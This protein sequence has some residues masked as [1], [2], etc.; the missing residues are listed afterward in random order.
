MQVEPFSFYSRDIT[1][2]CLG[3]VQSLVNPQLD[4]FRRVMFNPVMYTLWER[5]M[6]TTGWR[7]NELF[8]LLTLSL[9]V[10]LINSLV[11]LSQ[12]LVSG[13]PWQRNVVELLSQGDPVEIAKNLFQAIVIFFPLFIA[14]WGASL[15][16]PGNT[17]KGFAKVSDK[18]SV[19]SSSK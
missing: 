16:Q 12:R 10:A 3:K 7:N 15:F 8:P 14:L 19:E 5:L 17:G 11:N 6:V 2:Y 9:L 1:L 13:D 4:E 18:S